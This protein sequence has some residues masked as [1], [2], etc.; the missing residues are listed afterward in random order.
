VSYAFETS[1]QATL[2]T[3]AECLFEL[4]ETC[5]QVGGRVHLVK[6]VRAKKELVQ[7][8]YAPTLPDFRSL[9]ALVDPKGLLRNAFLE[10]T[11]GV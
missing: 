3:I 11:L 8:M 4:S 6:N 10:R 2:D 7:K 9:K 5:Y 1:N